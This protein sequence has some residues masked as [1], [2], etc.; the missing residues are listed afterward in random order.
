M[1]GQ[2]SIFDA[3][4]PADANRLPAARRR[5]TDTEKAAARDVFPHS[6]SQRLRVLEELASAGERGCTDYE[7]SERLHILRTSAG[8]RRKE[9]LEDG[10]VEPTTERRTT[11]TSSTAVVWRITSAGHEALGVITRE[12]M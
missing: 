7:L 9:L 4:G 5:G 8:K 1:T 11:D 6:G 3:I 12:A 10:L 2:L